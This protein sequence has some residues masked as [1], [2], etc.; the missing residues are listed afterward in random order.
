M[1]QST[2]VYMC[3]LRQTQLFNVWNTIMAPEGFSIQPGA[4]PQTLCKLW[5]KLWE[6]KTTCSVASEDYFF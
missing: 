3:I 5:L 4:A 2:R 1:G 6:R